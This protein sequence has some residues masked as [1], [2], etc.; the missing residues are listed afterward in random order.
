M[1]PKVD[2]HNNLHRLMVDNQDTGDHNKCN[3][4]NHNNHPQEDKVAAV[5]AAWAPVSRHC[6]VAALLRKDARLALIVLNA[7]KDAAKFDS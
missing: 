1:A 4:V 6:A 7:P 2:I 5:V 3:T